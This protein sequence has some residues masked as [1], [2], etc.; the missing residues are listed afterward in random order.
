[1]LAK[2]LTHKDAIALDAADPLASLSA[3]FELK[4]GAIFMDANSIGP[5][6]KVVRSTAMGLLDDWVAL[7]RRGWSNRQ[8]LD[9]PSLLGDAIAPIIGA[10]PGEVVVCDSTTINQFKA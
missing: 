4:P 1:M 5:M 9:M 2:A 3:L 7:R 10:D 8:W 6:P